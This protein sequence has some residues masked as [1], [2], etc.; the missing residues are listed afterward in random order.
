MS[1]FDDLYARPRPQ[2]LVLTRADD[3]HG[4]IVAVG[5]ES[6]WVARDDRFVAFAEELL[7][8]VHA[9]GDAAAG[10]LEPR[11]AELARLVGEDVRISG[12]RRIAAGPGERFDSYVHPPAKTIGVLVDTRG[13]STD[14]ARELAK[15]IAFA[16]PAYRTRGEAPAGP[17]DGRFYEEHVLEEQR[18]IHD[19]SLTVRAALAQGGAEVADYAWMSV[20]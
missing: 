20:A 8:R 18:W 16:R 15:H 7:E 2:G 12:A 9:D 1:E 11:R 19:Q 13:A 4:T 3:D 10:S 14:L 5:C 6:E 17:V